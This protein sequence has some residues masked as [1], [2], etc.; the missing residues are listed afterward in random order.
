MTRN[1]VA[2]N[3]LMFVLVIAGIIGAFRTKQEVFPEFS[4]DKVTVQVTYPGAS[5]SE[6]EQGLI[7][8]IEERVRGIDGVKRV[9]STA[10]EGSGT[11]SVDLLLDADPEQVLADV[12]GEVDRIQTFP[13][14]AEEPTI[15][16][17]KNRKQVVSLVLAGDQEL[18]TLH[19]IAERIRLGLLASP[20]ITSLELEGVPPLEISV[21]IPRQ[22]LRKF[23]L[24]PQ[25]VAAEI[26]ASSTE[27]PGGE[28]ETR[29]GE[30]NVR[31]AD[32]KR[33]GHELR[34]VILTRTPQGAEVTVGEIA[35]ITD[36]YE[37]V[38]RSAL[39]N[40]K[41]AVRI[42]V[43]RVG[44]QTPAS[45][46]A[47]VH[48][49]ADKIRNELPGNVE[50]AVW[51]D[52]SQ[53][54]RERM[55]LLLRNAAQG[56]VLV[57][58]ILALFLNLRLA[59][60]VALGIPISFLGSFV[61]LGSMD[62][63]I[64]MITLFAFIVTLGMVV[65]DAIVVGERV[66]AMREEGRSPSDAAVAAAR[67]MVVPVTFAI[68]TTIAAFAPLF[69]VPGTMGKIFKLIP[70]VVVAVLLL[71]LLESFFVLPAHL[72]HSKAPPTDK[73]TWR[74]PHRVVQAWVAAGLAA[75]T[76]RI[77]RPFLLSAVRY[78][79]LTIGAAVAVLVVTLGFVAG[80][81]VP[82]NFFPLIE[83]DIVKAQARLP[84]GSPLA[85]TARVQR[86]LERAATAA[87]L[88][89]GESED[90]RGMY[91]RLG[92]EAPGSGPGSGDPEKGSHI[93][94]VEINLVK[95][96]D[97]PFNAE[98]FAAAWQK[99][100]PEI[101]G[102]ESISFNAAMGPSAGAAVAVQL[103][104]DDNEV[105]AEASRQLA[106]ALEEYKELKNTR[107]SWAEGKPQLDFHL[108]PQARALG[109]TGLEVARQIRAAFHGVE[110]VRQQ[111]G[112]NEVKIVVRLPD[113]QR[114]SEHAID[115]LRIRTP[116]GGWVPLPYVAS[117]ERGRA[118]TSISRE[119]GQ[120]QVTVTA[121]LAPGVSSPR[122]VLEDLEK[123]VLVQLRRD[124][125]GLAVG[126]AGQQ[127]EQKETF[128]AL[129]SNYAVAMFIIFALLAVPFRS[130][131][132]PLIVMAVIPFG[133][134]GAIGGHALMGIG[135]S[136]MSMF[137]LVALSGVVVNDSLVLID[138]SNRLR[139]RGR[140]PH[141]AIVEAGVTRLRPIMLTSLTTF[142]G[143]VPIISETSVQAQF[144]VPMAVSLGFGVLLVTVIALVVVPALYMIV[145]DVRA[146]FGVG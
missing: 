67:E 119:D 146:L 35:T 2:A 10:R 133:F 49:Y 57:V 104:H 83:G 93:V 116:A 96:D 79:Y 76:Q 132:Q 6:V 25:Q 34:D 59:F 124:F 139:A 98:Q 56:L 114:A 17:A 112:R 29:R 16:L 21:E 120:R 131:V 27:L 138:A 30:I 36:G 103:G 88:E 58:L 20:D 64:N 13:E 45:V 5:P 1:S 15:A 44:D 73:P 38:D 141:D 70:A 142:F 127:R 53:I 129:G 68:L 115:A 108:R 77:Y 19:D 22:T 105:L 144:L 32:R 55:D 3:V 37:D 128:V 134:V 26:S 7:L 82:F 94:A 62:F 9:K 72:A 4:Q 135:L 123:T 100:T 126:M 113:D 50:I 18:R 109:L 118:A 99:H 43:F 136:I 107:N 74:S 11:V 69:F 92:E 81:H 41:P 122:E 60:W 111:R 42:T 117:F 89:L 85:E 143:L 40:G 95:G 31:V 28:L 63:S 39:F 54:L 52:D 78:R 121:E 102:L 130:Y 48:A 110:A 23:G 106:A 61:I 80:G 97:R 65:D 84:Y 46:A 137:G 8:A 86:Q 90:R 101:A 87:L 71:S 140:S 12:K 66:H 75:F 24:S 145:E 47:A 51:Q 33:E 14:D 91:T 125:P